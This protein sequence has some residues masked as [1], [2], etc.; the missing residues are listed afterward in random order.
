MARTGGAELGVEA[1]GLRQVRRGAVGVEA[2]EQVRLER[3][4]RAHAGHVRPVGPQ[5][6]EEGEGGA[7]VRLWGG[8]AY[9]L[10]SAKGP[11]VSMHPWRHVETLTV[12][13]WVAPR[14]AARGSFLQSPAVFF[15]REGHVSKSEKCRESFTPFLKFYRRPYDEMLYRSKMR[16]PLGGLISIVSPHIR[17][18][19]V[20]VSQRF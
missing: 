11:E 8:R 18:R 14:R 3:A 15:R 17:R 20:S 19:H 9:V 5:S 4:A 2:R 13:A 16:P 6:A 12:W 7:R 10:Q 1:P